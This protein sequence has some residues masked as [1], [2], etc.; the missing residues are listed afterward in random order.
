MLY[1][2]GS[3]GRVG[4]EVFSARSEHALLRCCALSSFVARRRR[5]E[6]CV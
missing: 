6:I 1:G 4:L 5:A 3:V 2:V